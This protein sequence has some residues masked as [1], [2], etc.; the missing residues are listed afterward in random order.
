MSPQSE[1]QL[2][3]FVI[4]ARNIQSFAEL[5]LGRLSGLPGN[6]ADLFALSIRMEAVFLSVL[7]PFL[8]LIAKDH[9]EVPR[10]VFD[11]ESA[12]LALDFIERYGVLALF[13]PTV[14]RVLWEAQR[15]KSAKGPERLRQVGR[16]LAIF[17]LAKKGVTPKVAID[18]S[19]KVF[20]PLFLRELE[21]LSRELGNSSS[22]T[23]WSDQ[24]LQVV[25]TGEYPMLKFNLTF[26]EQFL[27]C[28]V[29]NPD[30]HAKNAIAVEQLAAYGQGK[31]LGQH[32]KYSMTPDR[33]FYTWIAWATNKRASTVRREIQTAEARLR[34]KIDALIQ[35]TKNR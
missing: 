15:P 19:F 1:Q 35:V 7:D 21:R 34:R 33:F 11:E 27:R 14:L 24:M 29:T 26:L 25:T 12:D 3:D 2:P 28:Q 30:L 31:L 6:L 16:R 23:P 20:K 10:E 17:A 22:D 18:I 32:P 5:D 4:P 13:S 9:E 8:Q